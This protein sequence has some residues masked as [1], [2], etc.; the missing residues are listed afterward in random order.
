M[1]WIREEYGE[2]KRELSS[3]S[4]DTEAC[5]YRVQYGLGGDVSFLPVVPYTVEI[6]R[7]DEGD[8][9]FNHGFSPS[10]VTLNTAD[11]IVQAFWFDPVS[12]LD[13]TPSSECVFGAVLNNIAQF[14]AIYVRHFP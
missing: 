13:G 8:I 1:D 2:S 11:D 7:P 6:L 12:R 5:L 4:E 14:V 9:G 10:T 3:I